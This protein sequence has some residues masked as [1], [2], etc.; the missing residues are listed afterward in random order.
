M[1]SHR[2]PHHPWTWANLCTLLAAIFLLCGDQAVTQPQLLTNIFSALPGR[3]WDV[4][5]TDTAAWQQ[6]MCDLYCV[7]GNQHIELHTVSV[8]LIS[9]SRSVYAVAL[10]TSGGPAQALSYIVGHHKPCLA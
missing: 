5:L 9:I 1:V 4:D 2:T 7:L 10:Q 8:S 6:V 3:N